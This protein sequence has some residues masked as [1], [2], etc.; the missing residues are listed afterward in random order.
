MEENEDDK[1]VS[2][3]INYF[4][5]RVNIANGYREIPRQSSFAKSIQRMPNF[6]INKE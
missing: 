4:S 1:V 6:F 2:M 5:T 3:I